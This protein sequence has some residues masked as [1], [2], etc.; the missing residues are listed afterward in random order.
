MHVKSLWFVMLMLL[1]P[2]AVAKSLD[3]SYRGS[4]AGA[5]EAV[6]QLDPEMKVSRLGSIRDVPVVLDLKQA[7]K[8]DVLTE[9]GRQAG[10]QAELKYSVRSNQLTVVFKEAA[11]PAVERGLDGSVRVRFGQA[12]PELVCQ[13]L[14][15]CAIELERG[16]KIHRLDVGDSRWE[17]S[18]SLVGE[19]ET[20]SLVLIVRPQAQQSRTRLLVST[21]RR[22][23]AITLR[24]TASAD[25]ASDTRLSFLY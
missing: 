8:I 16:E 23:Y 2:W 4:L 7:S 14:D 24:S 9:M 1:P 6:R 13:T 10:D 11:K 18:P 5:L 20:S 19:K 3:I 15:V 17:V 25:D 12:K 21:N 22:V